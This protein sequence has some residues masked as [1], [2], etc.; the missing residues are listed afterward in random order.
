M[1]VEG[2]I[3]VAAPREQVFDRLSDARYE[4]TARVLAVLHALAD[5]PPRSGPER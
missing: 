2:D 1:N 3:N 5:R 4:D